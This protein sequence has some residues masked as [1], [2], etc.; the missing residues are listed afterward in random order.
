MPAKETGARKGRKMGKQ[1]RKTLLQYLEDKGIT[2]SQAIEM[3]KKELTN[4]PSREKAVL[5]P[6]EKR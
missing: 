6:Y 2:I 1:T 3:L 4:G 5:P